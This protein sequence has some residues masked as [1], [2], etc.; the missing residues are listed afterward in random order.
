MKTIAKAAELFLVTGLLSGVSEA[1]T[2]D[3]S[4][5][6]GAQ[7]NVSQISWNHTIGSGNNKSLIVS[8]FAWDNIGHDL[9]VDSIKYA[10]L[11][12]ARAASESASDEG[13][14]SA[15]SMWYLLDANLLSAGT[16]EVRI[17]FRGIIGSG[18]ASAISLNNVLQA[19]PQDVDSTI[20]AGMLLS[21]ITTYSTPLT[22]R[23]WCI[24]A[25]VTQCVTA[26]NAAPPQT[27]RAEVSFANGTGGMSTLEVSPAAQTG[28]GWSYGVNCA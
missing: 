19:A 20:Q 15:V 23:A 25:L 6:S 22:D 10:G 4:S 24:D 11:K 13:D 7:T 21:A 18:C 8:T 9:I 3:A 26:L 17:Y 1:I 27:E 28:I 16:Y 12:C 2:L 5:N 14:T